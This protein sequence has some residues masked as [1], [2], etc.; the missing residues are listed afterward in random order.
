[1]LL[2]ALSV[3]SSSSKAKRRKRKHANTNKFIKVIAKLFSL[4]LKQKSNLR[5]PTNLE[6]DFQVQF[7][8]SWYQ[9]PKIILLVAQF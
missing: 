5:Q 4:S 2:A 1:M 8:V 7:Y 9:A 6:A 3:P